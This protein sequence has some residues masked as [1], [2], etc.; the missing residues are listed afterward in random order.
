[1]FQALQHILHGPNR[2]QVTGV[3]HRW[4]L[5]ELPNGAEENDAVICFGSVPHA[6]SYVVRYQIFLSR[7]APV[8]LQMVRWFGQC[9]LTSDVRITNH[10]ALVVLVVVV[11]V[12][13]VREPSDRPRRR[14]QPELVSGPLVI[15]C[16]YARFQPAGCFVD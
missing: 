1:M 11:V 2:R 12:V 10:L 13:H 6:I 14:R 8:N 16:A 3:R 9:S 4:A 5:V 15:G 7:T